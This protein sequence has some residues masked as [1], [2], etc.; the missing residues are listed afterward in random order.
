MS[1]KG[2]GV[3]KNMKIRISICPTSL[4]V[5]ED[6]M[7]EEKYLDAIQAAVAAAFP[8]ADICL[9]VGHRQGDEW[10][11]VNGEELSALRALVFSIDCSDESICE[12]IPAW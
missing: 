6:A 12:A 5:G 2:S 9:Q 11:Q 7:D 1:K 3:M 10:F 8:D 4:E